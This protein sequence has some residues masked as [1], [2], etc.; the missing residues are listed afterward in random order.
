[1][2]SVGPLALPGFTWGAAGVWTLVAMVTI[3]LIKVWPVLAKQAIDARTQLRGEKRD[4]LRDL[5]GRVTALERMVTD[6]KIELSAALSAYRILAVEVES[7]NPTSIGLAQA[8][9]VLSTAF[10]VAPSTS[11]ATQG[12]EK[13]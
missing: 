9:A 5:G 11:P 10:T 4:D 6:L 12:E 3:A 7:N 8:R 1:M 2:A 13:K